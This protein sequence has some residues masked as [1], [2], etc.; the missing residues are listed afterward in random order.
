MAVDIPINFSAGEWTIYAVAG[1]NVHF[2]EFTQTTKLYVYQKSEISV[3]MRYPKVAQGEQVE[4]VAHLIAEDGSPLVD[5]NVTFYIGDGENWSVLGIAKTNSSGYAVIM[6]TANIETGL[7]IIKASYEGETYYSGSSNTYRIEVV[8]SEA[9]ILFIGTEATINVT[10]SDPATVVLKLYS[11]KTGE[12]LTNETVY[13][14]VLVNDQKILLGSGVTN[15]SGFAEIMVPSIDLPP[16]QYMLIAQWNGNSDYAP[17]KSKAVMIVDKESFGEISVEISPETIQYTDTI[18]VVLH[19]SDDDGEPITDGVVT[20]EILEGDVPV[21]RFSV[22]II[23]GTAEFDWDV[24]GISGAPTTLTVRVTAEKNTYY[25]GGVSGEATVGVE[26]ELINITIEIEDKVFVA[27]STEI[28]VII[29]DDEGNPVDSVDVIV[30]INGVEYDK[31]VAI[32]GTLVIPWV[33]SKEGSFKIKVVAGEKSP[34]YTRTEGE[35]TVNVID[36][37]K[38]PLSQNMLIGVIAAI[39]LIGVVAMIKRK[40]RGA[41]EFAP[42]EASAE[43]IEEGEIVG[44]EL[45]EIEREFEEHFGEP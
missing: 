19:A 23:N 39:A 5:R 14:Y 31:D 44:E 15:S 38:L 17:T 24:R 12:P 21:D 9:E 37:S 34:Y 3:T 2:A 10:F 13:L 42:E 7:Y 11:W 8:E 28:K 6:W 22:T 30:Y 45:E 43:A 36:R 41:L 32:N 20:V 1:D 26:K 18:N 35:V 25:F 40:R 33:P 27:E 29:T 4:I 16:A